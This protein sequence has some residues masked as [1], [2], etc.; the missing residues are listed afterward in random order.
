[1]EDV[2]PELGFEGRGGW[3]GRDEDGVHCMH[4]T[5]PEQMHGVQRRQEEAG[6]TQKSHVTFLECK[7]REFR[8]H[9]GSLV[10]GRRRQEVMSLQERVGSF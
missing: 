1:M 4:G 10:L 9:L 3:A 8:A 2:V 6:T 7:T 5:Q